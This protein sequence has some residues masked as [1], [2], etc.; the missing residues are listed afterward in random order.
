MKRNYFAVSIIIFLVLAGL[1]IF[2]SLRQKQFSQSP[3]NSDKLQV[4]TSFYPL[5]FM[6][7]EIGGDKAEITN[8][9][10]AGAEP[11]AYELTAR[12]IAQIENSRLLI[13]NGG[14]LEPWSS[15][16]QQNIN[17]AKTITG[18]AGE[19]L[20]DRPDPHF[21]LSPPLA[22]K[23]VDN[24]FQG[25]TAAD[26][27]NQNYYKTNADFLKTRLDNLDNE[28]K[29][30]LADCTQKN[31]VTAHEAF[32]YLAAAY[33]FNQIAIAGLSPE[34]E[35]S[36]KQLAEIAQLAKA[37]DLKYIFF[38]SLASPKLAET[39]AAEIKAETLVLNPIE[40][41]TNEELAQG[42]DYFTEMRANLVN[43]QT[44]LQCKK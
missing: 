8:I 31:I 18:V 1:T 17:P 43:L 10:P 37:K 15:N 12:D 11:H 38:E 29:N 44:A 5:Y 39:L 24:I 40:G 36:P 6:A 41:L 14:G 27:S 3:P 33:G 30:G 35:P 26:S 32:G 42:K 7:A 13:I 34:A 28:Y 23:M 16:I 2:I 22:K 25:F 19:N 20:S 4:T 21:W 9:T